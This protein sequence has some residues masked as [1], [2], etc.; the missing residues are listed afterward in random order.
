M[1]GKVECSDSWR[2]GMLRILGTRGDP[3]RG[4]FRSLVAAVLE[5]KCERLTSDG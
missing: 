5:E 2:I 4:L 3:I 1:S